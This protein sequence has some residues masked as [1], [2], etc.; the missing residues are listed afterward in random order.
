MALY[1]RVRVKGIAIDL[2]DTL[3]DIDHTWIRTQMALRVGIQPEELLSAFNATRVERNTGILGSA[4]ADM[5]QVLRVLGLR[6]RGLLS[7]L[8]VIER[9]LYM[10]EGELFPDAGPFT[11]EVRRR[12]IPIAIVSNCARGVRDLVARLEIGAMC[13]A[14]VLSFEVGSRKPELAIYGHAASELHSE[15]QNILYID[16]NE[17]FCGG[18]S[19][20]GMHP[21]VLNR[22]GGVRS[23]AILPVV[24]SLDFAILDDFFC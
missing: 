2:F 11:A 16:D 19:L 7:D 21:L 23:S 8:L 4:E 3:V 1:V 18:A 24:K 14:L 17:E 12:S 15:P 13:D 9:D 5:A 6:K 10:T 22:N 20:A